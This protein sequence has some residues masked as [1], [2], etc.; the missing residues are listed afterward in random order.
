MHY[1]ETTKYL[2]ALLSDENI[3]IRELALQAISDGIKRHES[4]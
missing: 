1:Y 4:S 2:F 3:N